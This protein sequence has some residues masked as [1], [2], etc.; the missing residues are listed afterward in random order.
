MSAAPLDVGATVR[1]GRRSVQRRLEGRLVHRPNGLVEPSDERFGKRRR[2][3]TQRIDLHAAGHHPAGPADHGNS[4]PVIPP[5]LI[6]GIL[7]GRKMFLPATS[8]KI[9]AVD[10]N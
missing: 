8:Y 10:P 4:H 1:S 7:Q 9:S 2:Q 5:E 6:E 3:V